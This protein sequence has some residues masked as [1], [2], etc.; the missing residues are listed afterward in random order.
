MAK[1]DG[2][3]QAKIAKTAAGA[4]AFTQKC[5]KC[6]DPIHPVQLIVSER[7]EKGSWKF[8]ER[9]LGACK[10]TSKEIYG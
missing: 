6:G 4:D 3:F 9:Y 5:P 7:T 1:K 10:C 2:S 8:N